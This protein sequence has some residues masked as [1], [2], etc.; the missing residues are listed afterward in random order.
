MNS[1]ASKVTGNKSVR[2]CKKFLY[3][4]PVFFGSLEQPK[5]L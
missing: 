5:R 3:A 4:A 2:R 1:I